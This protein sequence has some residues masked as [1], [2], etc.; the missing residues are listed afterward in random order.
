MGRHV[1][2]AC[3]AEA[4]AWVLGQRL[5]RRGMCP[6]AEGVRGRAGAGPHH[7]V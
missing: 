2:E 3:L 6:Q 5:P 7:A 1:G 4:C